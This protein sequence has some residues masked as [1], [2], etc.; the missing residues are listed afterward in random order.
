MR[1]AR[2]NAWTAAL[3]RRLPDYE[4][5]MAN[6]QVSKTFGIVLATIG[7]ILLMMGIMLIGSC[8]G[9]EDTSFGLGEFLDKSFEIVGYFAA[10]I[11][12]GLCVVG[13]SLAKKKSR[14]G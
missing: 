10:V 5:T 2:A 3:R 6:D 1:T 7:T 13:L 4:A 9:Y 12:G 11:G 8:G 14:S